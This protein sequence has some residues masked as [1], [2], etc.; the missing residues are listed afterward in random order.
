MRI[1]KSKRFVL[2]RS[3]ALSYVQN[4][5][6]SKE[7]RLFSRT[8]V[9]P[10]RKKPGFSPVRAAKKP[11]FFSRTGRS[12]GPE[13]AGFLPICIRLRMRDGCRTLPDGVCNPVRN[14]CGRRSGKYSGRG[15]KPRPAK[16]IKKVR[17]SAFRCFVLCAELSVQQRNPAFSPGRAF[18]RTEK[19]R[20]S[21]PS[22][23]QRNPAFFPG[24]GALPGRKKPGFSPYASG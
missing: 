19:S 5:L 20:V 12:P 11:G 22:V 17:T 4:Y 6:F 8:G 9:L 2:Q 13:K 14:V 21:P 24:Q 7:T 18:S 23:Q 3:D 1:S 10:G 15:C 16:Q